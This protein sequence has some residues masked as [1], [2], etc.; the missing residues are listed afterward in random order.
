MTGRAQGRYRTA[1]TRLKLTWLWDS[2]KM[3]PG[4]ASIPAAFLWPVS[5]AFGATVL[6]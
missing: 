5:A 1:Q 6:S 2:G 4:T 3:H